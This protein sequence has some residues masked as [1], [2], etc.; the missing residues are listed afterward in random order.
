MLFSIC[1]GVYTSKRRALDR[2]GCVGRI[3]QKARAPERRVLAIGHLVQI[4]RFRLAAR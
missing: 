4:A 3:P 2:R 1:G